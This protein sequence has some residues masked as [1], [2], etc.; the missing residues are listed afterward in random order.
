[1]KQQQTSVQNE[2]WAISADMRSMFDEFRSGG[3][4]REDADTGA[5]LAGKN[6]KA[7]S[8]VLADQMRLDGQLTLAVKA[9][10]IKNK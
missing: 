8:I 10:A 3:M 6:L 5:N 2:A 7:L 1:M 9:K 4:K